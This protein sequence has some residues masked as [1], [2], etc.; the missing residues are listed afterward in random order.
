MTKH[1]YILIF[2]AALILAW[3][4]RYDTHCGGNYSIAC[5][6]YDRFTGEWIVPSEKVIEKADE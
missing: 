4:F 2:I 3:W 1:H 5:V 6:A